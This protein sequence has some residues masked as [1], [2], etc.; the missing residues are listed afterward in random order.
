MS[1]NHSARNSTELRPVEL[2]Y[3]FDQL[4]PKTVSWRSWLIMADALLELSKRGRPLSWYVGFVL[5]G[6]WK[7]L[8][9]DAQRINLDIFLRDPLHSS[10]EVI[11]HGRSLR[12]EDLSIVR[13]YD[14]AIG[15]TEFLCFRSFSLLLVP[16]RQDWH[17]EHNHMYTSVEDHNVGRTAVIKLGLTIGQGATKMVRLC[18]IPRIPFGTPD[19]RGLTS[20][21]F[22][23]LYTGKASTVDINAFFNLVVLPAAQAVIPHHGHGDGHTVK[24]K[25]CI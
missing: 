25:L 8:G 21:L 12:V 2:R 20:V 17:V 15:T 18:D 9:V 5:S 16:R 24:C 10:R 6:R 13:D 11:R 22:P 19:A 3:P 14:S 23:A 7:E 1:Y 4:D